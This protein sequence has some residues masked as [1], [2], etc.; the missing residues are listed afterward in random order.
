MMRDTAKNAVKKEVAEGVAENAVEKEVVEKTTEKAIKDKTIINTVRTEGRRKI[1]T[2][3]SGNEISWVDQSPKDM[4]AI[5]K[6]KLGHAKKVSN[7][8]ELSSNEKGE[9]LEGQV[10]QAVQEMGLLKGVGLKMERMDK[11]AAGDIDVLTDKYII[12]IKKSL[13]GVGEKQFDKLINPNNAD[14]FNFDGKDIIYYI[15]DVTIDKP[16][17][18]KMYDML[19]NTENVKIVHNLEELKGVLLP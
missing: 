16:H 7:I 10:A 6:S 17:K 18:Q 14:Y 5:I 4:D 9:L 13:G 19:K 8:D 2:N 3:P 15:E 12:E 1:Y 11:T